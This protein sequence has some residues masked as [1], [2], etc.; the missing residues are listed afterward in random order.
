MVN[1]ISSW[2]KKRKWA[3]FIFLG[4]K[5]TAAVKLKDAVPWEKSCYK[6]RECI[7]KQNHHFA[8]KGPYSQ[9]CDLSSSKGS[10]SQVRLPEWQGVCVCSLEVH[11]HF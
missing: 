3:D 2:G 8:E 5:M 9:G 10:L 1:Q 11:I 7:K 4:F 6:P